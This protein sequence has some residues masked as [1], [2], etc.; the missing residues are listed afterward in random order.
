M[1][2]ED[3]IELYF[4]RSESAVVETKNKYEKYLIKIAYNV[5]ADTEDSKE[6][7]NSTYYAAW[8]TIP[9]HRPN[10]LSTYLGKITRRISIDMF[11]KRKSIKRNASEYALSLS[12]L[13]EC[14]SIAEDTP[15]NL[16]DAKVL[17]DAINRFLR[18]LPDDARNTFIGRYYFM[19]SL[20]D[21]AQYCGM[22]ESKAKS[23]LFR[24]RQHLKE[25][26]TKEGFVL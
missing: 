7:V 16:Y 15:E 20:R 6:S 24:T 13:D 10:I 25:F 8:N 3:I 14:F 1:R 9:P 23:L 26:L 5:L 2:D 22:S 12:E 17:A 21:V 4:R 18:T 11:R 19:D